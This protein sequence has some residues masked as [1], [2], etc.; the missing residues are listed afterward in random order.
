MVK[1]MP[2]AIA[3]LL[4]LFTLCSNAKETKSFP[5]HT[6]YKKS[7]SP[8]KYS[9]DDLDD[10]VR[11]YYRR[12][13]KDFLV[14]EGVFY[15]IA[16]DKKDRSRTVSEG[17]GY[18]MII[19]AFFAGEDKDAK[20]IFD[21]LFNFAKANP[22]DIRK[23]FMTWQV[24]AKKGESDSAFDGD[25]DIAFALLLADRQWGSE[26]VINYK[27]EALTVINS[28]LKY[29]VGA[30]SSLPLLG[31]WVD[32]NGKSYNQ[33]TTRSSDFLIS[34]FKTF[35]KYTKNDRWANVVKSCLKALT[36]IQRLPTNK[37]SLVSDFIIYK[38]NEKTYLPAPR[39]FLE[40][41]DD[42]Y[43]YNACR[44]P[45]RI[46][47][48]ALLNDDKNSKEILKNMLRWIV[49]S[50][51]ND[52]KNIKSGYRLDGVIIG[53]YFSIVFAAPFGVAAKAVLNQSFLDSVYE[54]IKDRHENYYEDSV[55][56]LSLLL[57]TNNYW[58]P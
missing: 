53:E 25:A 24:P 20:K 31:D 19:T 52:A 4:A 47:A 48:D 39:R 26:G 28:L 35:Y 45:L 51:K 54:T 7:I 30:K 5:S 32:P 27:K 50:T 12:W 15:R 8:S 56:L 58:S 38:K 16:T 2:F 11:E 21:G 13:K 43:Y 1:T 44:V 36:F 23:E 17:Q 49:K 34:H 3:V 37:T 9:Q 46:G 33:Y 42:S 22:S 40:T 10:H 57:I 41:E 29:T 18:G 14:K 6:V 55:T